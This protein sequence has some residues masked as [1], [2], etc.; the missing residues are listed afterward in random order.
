MENVPICRRAIHVVIIRQH[1]K[2]QTL[3]EFAWSDKKPIFIFFTFQHFNK[4]VQSPVHGNKETLFVKRINDRF[5]WFFN[6]KS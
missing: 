5:F 6:F 2:E 1:G 3:T 4:E